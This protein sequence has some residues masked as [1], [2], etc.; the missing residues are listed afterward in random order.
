MLVEAE[1]GLAVDRAAYE[2]AVPDLRVGLVNAQFDLRK[3][4]F[5]VLVLVVGDD[6]TGCDE[7]LDRLHE[8]LDAGCHW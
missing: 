8:W 1:A 5:A 4:G 7:V 3:A 6:R 2:A